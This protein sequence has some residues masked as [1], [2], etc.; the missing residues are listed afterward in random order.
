MAK[1]GLK[2]FE[3]ALKADEALR[4]RFEEALKNVTEAENDG[5]AIQEAAA[6]LG[7]EISLEE[8]E[9]AWA[10]SQELDDAELDAVAGGQDEHDDVCWYDYYCF[11]AWRH[12]DVPDEHHPR[13]WTDFTMTHTEACWKDYRCNIWNAG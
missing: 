8:L 10:D 3:D 1:T 11:G 6:A 12:D 7:Y 4:A 13:C 5:E 9:Q 2:T